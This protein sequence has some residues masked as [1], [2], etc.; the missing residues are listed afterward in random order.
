M[1]SDM[2]RLA[3][4]AA[5]AVILSA[6]ELPQPVKVDPGGPGKAPSDAVVL[7]DGTNLAQWVHKDGSPAKW[8]VENGEIV[9]KTGSGNIHTK[10]KFKDFQLHIEFATPD[11]T[12]VTGQA[13]GNSGVYLQGR[14]ELQVLDSFDNPTYADG[15]AGA[16]YQQSAPAVN[17]SRPPEQWQS[18]DIIFHAAK[19]YGSHFVEPGS[20]TVLHNGV[21][22]QDGFILNG[23]TPGGLGGDVCEPGPIMLQDHI[24]PEIEETALR[25]RNIWIRPLD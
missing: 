14:Y 8:A 13:R 18:Y 20:V 25:F 9:C 1:P 22:I 17:A 23:P 6:A 5:S 10:R 15:S 7:F 3:L 16:I 24:H 4:L 12:N 11:Q 21:L 19:C 2:K